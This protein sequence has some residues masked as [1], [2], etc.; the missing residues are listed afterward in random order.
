MEPMS[1][2]GSLAFVPPE[3]VG[4][5]IIAIIGFACGRELRSCGQLEQQGGFGG[6]WWGLGV[7]A[8]ELLTVSIS[9]LA[10]YI[11][12]SYQKNV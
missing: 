8:F 2:C 6:D 9:E 10:I 1:P 3:T 5:H 12:I 11:R 7:I 4:I